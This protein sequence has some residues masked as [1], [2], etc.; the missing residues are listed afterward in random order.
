MDV[1]GSPELMGRGGNPLLTCFG[2]W[3]LQVGSL[4]GLFWIM[5]SCPT[6]TP[7]MTSAKGAKEASRWPCVRLKVRKQRA[8]QP[9]PGEDSKCLL[10]IV[11]SLS[12]SKDSI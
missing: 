1:T 7:R 4:D 12:G 6:T 9:A 5:G 2:L 8:P 10:T 11:F 3:S